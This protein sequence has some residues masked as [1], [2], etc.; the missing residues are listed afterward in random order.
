L[1]FSSLCFLKS[2]KGAKVLA[3]IQDQ[4]LATNEVKDAA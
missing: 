4:E 3:Q 1:F 2:F